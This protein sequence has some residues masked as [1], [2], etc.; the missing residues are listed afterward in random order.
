M[1]EAG[2]ADAAR[3]PLV[4][5]G[6]APALATVFVLAPVY[7]AGE[8]CI[9]PPPIGYRDVLER[10]G[11]RVGAVHSPPARKAA[12][13]E[14]RR[15]V[16]STLGLEL[17]GVVAAHRTLRKRREVGSRAAHVAARR[18]RR[19]RRAGRRTLDARRS[20]ADQ[21][22]IGPRQTRLAEGLVERPV[23]LGALDRTSR[24]STFATVVAS[25]V[26]EARAIPRPGEPVV[27]QAPAPPAPSNAARVGN[28]R[29]RFCLVAALST[30]V[31]RR[32]KIACLAL[33]ALV[34][35]KASE[36]VTRREQVVCYVAHASAA[37]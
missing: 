7:L 28:P 19:R 13:V 22:L 8:Q 17:Y 15:V 9:A 4:P 1:V 2:L 11:R 10:V 14:A 20:V 35:G 12:L 5:L 21:T 26:W 29:G 31:A 3:H 16:V 36:T 37:A 25:E 32:S 27:A 34:T 6:A 18:T 23:L 24:T 33:V 30:E